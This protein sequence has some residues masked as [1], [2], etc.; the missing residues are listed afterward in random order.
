MFAF[1]FWCRLLNI[2]IFILLKNS[3]KD[4]LLG[5][6]FSSKVISTMVIYIW[7]HFHLFLLFYFFLDLEAEWGFK[8]DKF[9]IYVLITEP[10][11][12]FCNYRFVL[13]ILAIFLVIY[14]YAS[15]KKCCV[16]LNPLIIYCVRLLMVWDE[17]KWSGYG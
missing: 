16:Q 3:S 10:N 8:F 6:V 1:C 4:F 5:W 2:C 15:C 12:I 13:I 11:T 14:M 7:F 17:L 9:S